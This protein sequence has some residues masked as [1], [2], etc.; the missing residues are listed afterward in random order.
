MDELNALLGVAEALCGD[1]EVS[2]LIHNLQEDLMV[3]G[4]DLA[5]PKSQ[6]T[7]IGRTS[8]QMIVSLEL[9]IDRLTPATE[10]LTTFILPGGGLASSQLHHV[11][12]VSRRA[13][14][15]L[16]TLAR[17]AEVTPQIT[18]YLNRLGDLLFVLA[19][20]VSQQAGETEIPWVP[21]QA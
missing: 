3:V 16:A 9:H 5:T 1:A 15:R 6:D 20:W 18:V 13:E 12:T 14:R 10:P 7:G 21:R 2:D 11:R 19:R 4:A 17:S 8:E